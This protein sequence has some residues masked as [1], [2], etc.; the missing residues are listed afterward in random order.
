VPHR[1][2]VGLVRVV[3]VVVALMRSMAVAVVKIVDVVL[4]LD[5]GV[6][7]VWAV[8]VY[9]PFGPEMPPARDP[10]VQGVV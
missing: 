2:L 4:V 10:A 9:V 6:A 1:I 8:F 7:A 3:L 5:R